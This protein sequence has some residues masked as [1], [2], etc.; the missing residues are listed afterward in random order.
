MHG[1][2]TDLRQAGVAFLIGASLNT[3][4]ERGRRSLHRRRTCRGDC[5]SVECLRPEV[6]GGD[7]PEVVMSVPHAAGGLARGGRGHI[8]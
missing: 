6:T 5:L 4:T 2:P 8:L 7:L 1:E 3:S